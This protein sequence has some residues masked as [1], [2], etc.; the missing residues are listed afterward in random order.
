MDPPLGNCRSGLG[1]VTLS[2]VYPHVARLG[3]LEDMA[4]SSAVQ[5]AYFLKIFAMQ[6]SSSLSQDGSALA[7]VATIRRCRWLPGAKPSL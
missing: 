2:P 1:L 7:L 5:R 6:K 4:P 3:C